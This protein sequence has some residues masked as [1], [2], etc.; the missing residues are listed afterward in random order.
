M[1][2]IA[3]ELGG[4][5]LQA[6]RGARD[7]ADVRARARG[8]VLDA[9]RRS[10][11]RACSTCSP[12]R[13]ALGIEALSRGAAQA[14]FVERDGAALARAAREPG[15]RSGSVRRERRCAR[16]DALRRAP[17]ARRAERHTIWSSSTLPT[18]G[19]RDSGTRA[20]GGARR[21]V[22][23]RGG[24]RGRARATGERRWSSGCA[25]ERE[26]RYGDTLIRIHQTSRHDASQRTVDRRLPG[27][28]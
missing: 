25:L 20:L 3:G 28:L 13:G 12:A 26:R 9:R 7:A 6:P 17:A 1:R 27:L 21:P 24:A 5:R 22:L 14:V 2:V 11:A 18:R 10:T 19:G 16:S 4:R 8:A 23:G 15:R